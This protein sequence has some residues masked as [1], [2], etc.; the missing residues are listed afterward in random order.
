MILT[1]TVS[2][3]QLGIAAAAAFVGG[4][5]NSVAGGGTLLTFPAL[6][7]AGLSPL[8][9]N[10]TSTVALLPGALSSMLGYR[11]E[12]TGA[13]EWTMKVTLPSLLGGGLGAWLLLKTPDATFD[14]IVPW[15]VLGATTLFLA[16]RPLMAWVRRRKVQIPRLRP[17][18]SARNDG[19]AL[20]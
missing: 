4:I 20:P 10:A 16:Q 11:S 7:A 12:L 1:F 8:V 3:W 14:R 13:R 15:L 5:M 19:G 17:S 2:L 6:I 18:A 9:A